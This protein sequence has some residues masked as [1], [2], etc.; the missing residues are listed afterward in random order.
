[1]MHW[2][3]L[4][5]PAQ[6]TAKE[7]VVWIATGGDG[8]AYAETS[9]ALSR[10]LPGVE[11]LAFPWQE[12]S[13][14]QG[15]QPAV[16]VALGAEALQHALDFAQDFPRTPLVGLLISRH[17]LESLSRKS[18]KRVTGIYLDQPFT[19][20][21]QWLREAM[22]DLE[23]IGFLLGPNSKSYAAEIRQAAK[24][25]RFEAIVRVAEN[26]DDAALRLR[27]LLPEV[28]L[29]VVV[30]DSAIFNG[31]MLQYALIATYRRGIPAYGYSAPMVKSGAIAA[32]VASPGQVGRQGAGLVRRIL[33]TG[34]MPT[35]QAPDDYEIRINE[36][37]ARSL[38]IVIEEAARATRGR[39]GK[40]T[41]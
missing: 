15:Q 31:Q 17:S 1:M 22:P 4:L 5:I 28:Q 34:A 26:S 39:A 12:L 27:D 13:S 18:V 21:M 35:V 20:Q 25:S 29:F 6:V 33:E 41:Q 32:L 7:N 23:R 8:G 38:G 2:A 10:Q 19:R 36:S 14:R 24:Q 40:D 11:I 9:A 16:I 30:P 37:V 3:L